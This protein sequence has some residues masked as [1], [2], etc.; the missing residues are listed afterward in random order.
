[1]I[2]WKERELSKGKNILTSEQGNS[3]TPLIKSGQKHMLSPVDDWK[4]CK[5]DDIVFC[6]VKGKY[7]TH[8]VG[9]IDDSKGLLI[10]NNHGHVNGWTKN[11]YGKVT[12][13]L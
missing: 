5:I 10:K 13:I 3:M 8:L 1:M 9:A 7:Y 12:K 4:D 2:H 6:K 11:V